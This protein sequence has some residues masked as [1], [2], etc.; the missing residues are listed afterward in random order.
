MARRLF[1]VDAIH[2][3]R[4]ELSGSEAEHLT[5]VLRVKKGQRFEVSDN[6]ALYLAEV[7]LARK[8]QVIFRL[9]EKLETP[10]LPVRIH[11]AAALI[12][13]ER[14]EWLLEKAA[15][16]GAEQVTPV[17]AGRSEKGL[18]QAARKRLERWRRI[19][20]ESSQQARRWRMPELL[21]PAPLAGV[22]STAGLRYMLDEAPAAPL[23][24]VLPQQRSRSDVVALLVGPEGGWTEAE[25][26]AARQ[27]D[28]IAASLGPTILRAETAAAAAVAIISAA[29]QARGLC[30]TG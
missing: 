13:F 25:R 28:W 27:A 20:R 9:V 26:Q 1:F 4:A 23:L 19:L 7:D 21:G 2:N 5:R 14:F 6:R 24:D 30:G 29:W 16:L 17:V 12:K 22:L 3:Q 18:E 8:E 11:L 15:E 10:P